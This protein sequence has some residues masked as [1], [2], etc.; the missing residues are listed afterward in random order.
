MDVK[1]VRSLPRISRFN[2]TAGSRAIARVALAGA[3]LT[4]SALGLD[5][6]EAAPPGGKGWNGEPIVNT[7]FGAVRGFE[8]LDDTWVWKAIPYA[9]PPVGVLR[10]RAPR[11][12]LLW[13]EIRSERSFNAGCTQYALLSPKVI[14]GSEDCLYLNVW[15]PRD[16]ETGLPVYV[17]IHGGGNTMGWATQLSDYQ[18]SRLAARS[19]MVFVSINYRLGPFGW[20]THPALREGQSD[21]DASG[22]Y[23][24]L[25]MI[26]A[27][28][29]IRDNIQA[30]GGDPHRVTLTG[31]SA[32][33]MDVLALLIAPKAKGLFQ[34]AVVQSGVARTSS[35]AEADLMSRS[36]IEQLLVADGTAKTHAQ[37]DVATAAMTR[38]ALGAY[39][40]NKSDREI[41]RTYG[42]SKNGII[43]N[44]DVLN[45]GA[46]IPIEGFDSFATG[47]YA[48][49]VPIILGGNREELK[50]ILASSKTIPWQGELFQ[51]VVK[52]G[53]ARWRAFG[54]DEV[55]H[56]LA[57]HRD[58]PPVYTY[59][60][61]W[62]APDAKGTSVLPGTWGKRLGAFHALDIPFFLGND[63]IFGALQLMLFTPANE[64]GRKALSAA[65]MQYL[66]SFARTGNPNS[67]E[68]ILPT[69]HPWSNVP[70][71]MKALVFDAREKALAISISTEELTDARVL[72]AT[73][74]DLVEPMRGNVLRYLDKMKN[75]WGLR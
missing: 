8:D 30:F 32:G 74:T 14:R 66:A 49:K 3:L 44:P 61:D 39:L 60:F 58:Q 59:R 21:V 71:T 50:S 25:D 47:R 51:A 46:V 24:L 6:L 36:V 29:W 40:R 7:R 12:P 75:P 20:F 63:T 10:W 48:S 73:N 38:L 35:V 37:A 4:L 17:F 41:L 9:R 19:R 5:A 2:R 70:G 27:L 57:T 28:G 62:G 72:R 1:S 33:G 16:G 11:D 68:S 55:A 15:R 34:R 43:A 23:G 52:Y 54:V 22:N 56:R 18:G 26:K 45:D 65:M 69:W 42:P 53:S 67:R 13:T 31:Q 64:P